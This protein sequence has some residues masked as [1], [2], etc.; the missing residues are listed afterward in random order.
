MLEQIKS[1]ATTIKSVKYAPFNEGTPDYTVGNQLPDF[2]FDLIAQALYDDGVRKVYDKNLLGQ[3]DLACK[4]YHNL[5]KEQAV[6]QF[7]DD[8]CECLYVNNYC[9]EIVTKEIILEA[10]EAFKKRLYGGSGDGER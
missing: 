6:K 2:V 10:F 3:W 5:S 8:L 4:N 9:Q 1:I 7:V